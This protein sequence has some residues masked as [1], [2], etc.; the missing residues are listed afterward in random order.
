MGNTA[1]LLAKCGR[2]QVERKKDEGFSSDIYGPSLHALAMT[3][4]VNRLLKQRREMDAIATST[5]RRESRSPGVVRYY[6]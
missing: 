4:K 1:S 6:V 3:I 2:V 5:E